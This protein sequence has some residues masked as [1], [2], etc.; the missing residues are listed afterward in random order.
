M[1]NTTRALSTAPGSV[2]SAPVSE[3]RPRLAADS[4]PG[5]ITQGS[6][7]CAL[8]HQ[9]SLTEILDI[10][11]AGGAV[12]PGPLRVDPVAV[13]MRIPCM[14][15]EEN[16]APASPCPP[17]AS[18]GSKFTPAAA[19]NQNALRRLRAAEEFAVSIREVVA[20]YVR[21]GLPY[22][23]GPL[24]LDVAVVR[25]PIFASVLGTSV[26]LDRGTNG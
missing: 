9:R 21:A 25:E 14:V 5:F 15:L 7:Q 10:L 26:A 23:P 24:T 8:S 22:E 20:G 13:R 11:R 12:E 4:I 2:P 18:H 19:I 6:L 17:Q 3:R 16:E 1:N